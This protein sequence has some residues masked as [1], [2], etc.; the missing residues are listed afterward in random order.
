MKQSLK[1]FL[2]AIITFLLS[3]VVFTFGFFYVINKAPLGKVWKVNK[4][5]ENLYVGEY[6]KEKAELAA[7]KALVES[8][9]DKYGVYYDGDEAQAMMELVEGY[10]V[11]IGTEIFANNEKNMIEVVAAYEDSPAYK[12]GIES[13]DLIVSID[14]I[15]YSAAQMAEATVYM[16][17]S[18]DKPL[19]QEIVLVVLR[20]EEQLTMKMKRE[21]ISLYKVK[22]KMT[23]DGVFYIRYS[24]FTENS[25]KELQKIVKEAE[26]KNAKAL[27][28]DVR[29][30]PGG[31]FDS[32]IKMC[33]LFLDSGMIMYTEDKEG[34]KTEYMATKGAS[35]LPLAVLVN[36]ASASSA[37]IFAA[38]MQARER[39]VIVGE[40]TFG[41][42]VSQSLSYLN[43]FDEDEGMVKITSCKNFAPNGRWINEAVVPDI[44]V[45]T[46]ADFINPEKDDA[47]I[48]AVE[49]LRE[50]E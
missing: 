25:E 39:A 11:G 31:D 21:K 24:G 23:D 34:N 17:G 32:A 9:G 36:E 6:D 8:T 22:G 38:S 4:M 3:A 44:I 37:E 42:G 50:K 33:D 20:G 14:G 45:E 13:G 27:V 10:Y 28:I 41:K 19:N 18:E 5:I 26:K 1:I 16:R 46:K 40:K 2:T 48:K 49:K 47:F 30:N 35:K 43:P 29:D 7:V 15:K 12:A